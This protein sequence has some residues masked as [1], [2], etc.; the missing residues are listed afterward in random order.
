MSDSAKKMRVVF[1]VFDGVQLLDLAGPAEVL[2]MASQCRG[3]GGYELS[4]VGPS[5]VPLGSSA[6]V[7]L[8]ATPFE[9]YPARAAIHTLVIPGGTLAKIN[10]VLKDEAFAA[11]IRRASRRA[12]RVASVCTGAFVLSALGLLEG[13][14]A[15]THWAAAE[16]LARTAPNTRVD[17][18][19]LFIE[20][21]RVWTSAG[22]TTGMDLTLALVARDLGREIALQV[23]R[24]LVLNLVRPGGQSQFSA[25]L[26]LQARAS[27]DLARL[28]PWLNERLDAPVT[29]AA[30][31]DAMGM[32]ERSFQ[33][34]CTGEFGMAP[35]RLLNEL[36]LERARMLLAEPNMRIGSVA[37]Q[38][39]FADVASFSKAFT[40]R[41]G[42]SPT[43]YRRSFMA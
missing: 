43:S 14:R 15:T 37:S 27:G 16:L 1:V 39:G 6:G 11:W 21:G 25:P 23:A 20:D 2:A 7:R 38:T 17:P 10:A 40:K 24:E 30:M 13:K 32:S 36:R 41:F 26:A 34:R 31:A 4:F 8:V 33:R 22:V 29:V 19:A 9:E 3:E 18:E 28:L 35:A 42:G 12:S 5:A